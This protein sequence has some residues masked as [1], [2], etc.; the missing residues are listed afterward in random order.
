LH[1]QIISIKLAGFKKHAKEA[2]LL[3][4]SHIPYIYP[5]NSDRIGIQY[6]ISG[7]RIPGPHTQYHHFVYLPKGDMVGKVMDGLV[8]GWDGLDRGS[9]VFMEL[10]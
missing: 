8:L 5:V 1:T 3:Y 4:S 2:A 9:R 6:C 10:Y 7:V